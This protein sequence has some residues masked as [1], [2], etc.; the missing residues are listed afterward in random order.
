MV[1]KETAELDTIKAQIRQLLGEIRWHDD[2]ISGCCL[3]C[4][5]TP[6]YTEIGSGRASRTTWTI[7][8]DDDCPYTKLAALIGESSV[9]EGEIR[10]HGS[11]CNE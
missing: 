6:E 4:G 1:D 8:H 9:Q 2:E 7:D 5:A 10:L 11:D 3:N